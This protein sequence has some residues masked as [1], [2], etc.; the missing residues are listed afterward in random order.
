LHARGRSLA[1]KGG[2]HFKRPQPKKKKREK[3]RPE[4]GVKKRREIMGGKEAQ[5]RALC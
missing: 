1:L 2:G 4:P 3:R 5:R